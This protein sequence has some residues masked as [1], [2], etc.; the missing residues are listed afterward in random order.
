[1]VVHARHSTR[2]EC[3]VKLAGRHEPGIREELGTFVFE[4][5]NFVAE[6]ASSFVS[7]F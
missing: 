3:S 1:M 2:S 7:P 4:R 6:Y 5:A